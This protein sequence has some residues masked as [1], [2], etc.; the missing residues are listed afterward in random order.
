MRVPPA[1]SVRG[2]VT[3]RLR[4]R[5]RPVAGATREVYPPDSE[6]EECHAEQRAYGERAAA[7]RDGHDEQADADRSRRDA[8]RPRRVAIA[9]FHAPHHKSA[10][11]GFRRSAE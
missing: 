6:Q 4:A 10:S 8:E 1:T 9:T 11:R 3:P 5:S 7:A 2:P